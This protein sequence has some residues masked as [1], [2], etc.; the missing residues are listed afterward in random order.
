MSA[1]ANEM[2]G[3]SGKWTVN[4]EGQFCTTRD[5]LGWQNACGFVYGHAKKDVSYSVD[6]KGVI[7]FTTNERFEDN[8]KD[9]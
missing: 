4:A 3:N 7:N 6:V 2:F 5:D 9:L 8:P 1:V